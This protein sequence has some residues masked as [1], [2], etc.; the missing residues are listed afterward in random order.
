M[1]LVGTYVGIIDGEKNG[2]IVGIMVGI[3]VT[4]HEPVSIIVATIPPLI[5]FRH[6]F[7]LLIGV[8]IFHQ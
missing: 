1:D 3:S 5:Q 7:H 8:Y 2:C 4:I 6:V